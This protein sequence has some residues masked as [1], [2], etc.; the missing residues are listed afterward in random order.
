MGRQ[1]PS[2]EGGV[3]S[4]S[5]RHA[6]FTLAAGLR[7]VVSG[8]FKLT[9]LFTCSQIVFA[10]G[11]CKS[12]ELFACLLF[13][14]YRSCL[15][16]TTFPASSY[17]ILVRLSPVPASRPCLSP[18]TFPVSFTCLLSRLPDPA[19]PRLRSPS[20]PSG[21]SFACLLPRFPDPAC[22]RLRS[23]PRPR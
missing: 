11:S 17:W 19:C 6:P 14:V 13:P 9:A 22:P 1:E 18:T 23:S 15:F 12:L 20:R 7:Q 3:L 5:V 10:V 4:R 2:L 21:S 16:P 8:A